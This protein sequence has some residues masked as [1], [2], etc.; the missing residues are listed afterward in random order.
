MSDLITLSRQTALQHYLV[1]CMPFSEFL[2]KAHRL[3]DRKLCSYWCRGTCLACT[4]T[5]NNNLGMKEEHVRTLN[6]LS[7]TSVSVLASALVSEWIQISAAVFRSVVFETQSVQILLAIF[8]IIFFISVSMSQCIFILLPDLSTCS[9][10]VKLSSLMQKVED[11][12]QLCSSSS[13]SFICLSLCLSVCHCL[14]EL[15]LF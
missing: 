10:T 9:N 2:L 1:S 8:A 15:S 3:V 6:K 11:F 4:S 5:S 13:I 7:P 14:T 12:P